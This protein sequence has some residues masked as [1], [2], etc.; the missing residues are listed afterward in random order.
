VLSDM[1]GIYTLGLAPGSILHHNL[2]HDVHAFDYG[3]WGVYFD[4]GTTGMVAEDNIIYDVKTG[5]FHQHYG[6]DNIVRNNI[7]AFSKQYQ[8]Q[9]S[10]QEPHRSFT[11]ERNIVYWN[12]GT[13]LGSQWGDD[14]FEMDR[15]IYWRADGKPIEFAGQPLEKWQAKG[16]D[17]NSF[18]ADPLFEDAAK[19]KFKLKRGSPAEKIKFEPIDLTGVGPKDIEPP[20]DSVPPAFP[21]AK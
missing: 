4:E 1:G 19:A 5:G 7:F 2:I 16:M 3:G 9:R 6:R 15:N 18:I 12:S 13:L 14:K 20:K 10:R 21:T 11:F 17:K 8:L